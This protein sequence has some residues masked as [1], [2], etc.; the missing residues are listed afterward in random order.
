MSITVYPELENRLRARA[1][2]AGVTLDVYVE[3]LLLADSPEGELQ[4]LALEGVDSGE[5]FAPDSSYWEAKHRAL[6][7]RL[8]ASQ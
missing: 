8:K 5:P 3:R 2:A 6:D 7:E 1:E 4:S